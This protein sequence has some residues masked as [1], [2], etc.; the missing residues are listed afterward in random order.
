MI[1]TILDWRPYRYFTVEMEQIPGSIVFLITYELEALQDGGTRVTLRSRVKRAA[2]RWLIRGMAKLAFP[3][4]L[5]ADLDRME[6]LMS[7]EKVTAT[8]VT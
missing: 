7:E 6:T 4:K 2:A 8:G 1:E 5:G 3:R